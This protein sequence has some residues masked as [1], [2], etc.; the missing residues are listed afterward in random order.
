M[1]APFLFKGQ[2]IVLNH[3]QSLL[4][5][6]TEKHEDQL[7]IK[8]SIVQ[9]EFQNDYLIICKSGCRLAK[10]IIIVPNSYFVVRYYV[11]EN[12]CKKYKK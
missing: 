9:G 5:L 11:E 8:F 2:N 1:A 6:L 7:V 3:N 10:S 12:R 4:N